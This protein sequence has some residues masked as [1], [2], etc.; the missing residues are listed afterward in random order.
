MNLRYVSQI[1]FYRNLW[2]TSLRCLT[3]ATTPDLNP[4]AEDVCD[5]IRL[6]G[7]WELLQKCNQFCGGDL[8]DIDRPLAICAR[9]LQRNLERYKVE[10]YHAKNAEHRRDN[11]RFLTTFEFDKASR[12]VPENKFIG[13]EEGDNF[14]EKVGKDCIKYT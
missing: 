12:T 9:S 8:S 5:Q 7:G 6:N 10:P 1:R 11:V 14:E 13:T 3:A 4:E 2:Y